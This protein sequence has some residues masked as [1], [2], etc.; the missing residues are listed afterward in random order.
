M[1]SFFFVTVISGKNNFV[2]VMKGKIIDKRRL[3]A[4]IST[5]YWA[6]FY[7]LMLLFVVG[8]FMLYSRRCTCKKSSRMQ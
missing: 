6:Q 1:S 3:A 7:A 8:W 2:F 4:V 5:I